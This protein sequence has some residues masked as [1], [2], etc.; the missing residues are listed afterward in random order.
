MLE[1]NQIPSQLKSNQNSGRLPEKPEGIFIKPTAGTLL[2]FTAAVKSKPLPGNEDDIVT[3]A[4]AGRTELVRSA[5]PGEKANSASAYEDD[6]VGDEAGK[7]S[8][9]VKESRRPGEAGGNRGERGSE[10]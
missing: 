2:A 4:A 10:E 3:A 8:E 6:A 5:R 7:R 9:G 1:L